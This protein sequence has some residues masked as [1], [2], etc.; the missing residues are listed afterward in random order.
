M[1][2]YLKF[3]KF[4][5]IFEHTDGKSGIGFGPRSQNL[6]ADIS[7]RRNRCDKNVLKLE[8]GMINKNF[9]INFKWRDW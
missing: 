2:S 9:K 4:F 5:E 1:N 6:K 3:W 7:I 8:L